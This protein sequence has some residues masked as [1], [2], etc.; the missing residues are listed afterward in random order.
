MVETITLNKIHQDV[1]F[2]KQQIAEVLH[3]IKIEPELREE[4]KLQVQEA[5]ERIAQGKFVSNEEILKEF[6]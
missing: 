5:R 1:E 6:A 3:L 4:I 2:L